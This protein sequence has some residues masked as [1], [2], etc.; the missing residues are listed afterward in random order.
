M[1]NMYV[2]YQ[3]PMEPS[4]LHKGCLEPP[5]HEDFW[6]P[7]DFEPTGTRVQKKKENV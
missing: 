7:Q 1:Q 4:E 3:G 6:N 5:G 2:G